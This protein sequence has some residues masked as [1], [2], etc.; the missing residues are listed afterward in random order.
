MRGSIVPV[1]TPFKNGA[2]DLDGLAGLIEWQIESGS[3]GVSVQGT[4]GEPSSLT[5]DERKQVIKT[6]AEVVNK[7]VPFVAGSASTNHAESIELSR[8]AQ[9][10]GADAVLF[11]SPYYCRPSQEGIYQHFDALSKSVDVPVILYNIPGRT[12]VN[13]E[14][15]TV[16][17]LKEANDNIIGVKESNKDFEHINRLL[18]RMGRD[19]LVYSGIELLCYPIIAIGGAG[20]VSA[21]G[22]LMPGKVASL[23]NLV[24]EGKW[25]E[26]Q[27]LH[28]A[29]MTLNDAIFM[30]INPVPVKA[31]LGMMGKISPEVRLPLSPLSDSNR[32][33]LRKILID[34]KLIE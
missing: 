16:A 1:V 30:E 2:L 9:D 4:T 3:H 18:H 33:K 20:F 23:Y 15:D 21:T 8:Y 17:R 28:Y 25:Q 31:A 11:I 13:I 29:M 6:A 24:Q 10:V 7:R 26:A 32:E 14:I 5:L 34:Y 22:N 27:D 19:F 12:A